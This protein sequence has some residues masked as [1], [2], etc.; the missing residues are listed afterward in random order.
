MVGSLVLV[1][2]SILFFVSEMDRM[3]L[4]SLFVADARYDFAVILVADVHG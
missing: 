4:I 1:S 2:T 3:L